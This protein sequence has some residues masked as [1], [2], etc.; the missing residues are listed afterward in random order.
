MLSGQDPSN[1][2]DSFKEVQNSLE[3]IGNTVYEIT[4]AESL[5]G[6]DVKLHPHEIAKLNVSFNSLSTRKY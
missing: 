6:F 4:K 3:S 2:L 5:K 1:S